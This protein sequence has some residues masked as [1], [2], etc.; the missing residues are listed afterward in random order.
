MKAAACVAVILAGAS[1]SA[2]A[3]N[4][5]D[6]D[7]DH[8]QAS[9][10]A[11]PWAE[12]APGWGHSAGEGSES[13]GELPAAGYTQTFALL[14][15]PFGPESGMFGLGMRGGTEHSQE[16][17]GNFIQAFVS[18]TGRVGPN[19]TSVNLLTNS[20]MFELELDGNPIA[21]NPVGLDP[22][23]AT[24]AED[25]LT[26]A[27]EWTGDVSAFAGQ[28]VELKIIDLEVPPDYSMLIIDQIQ[29]LPVPETPT[30]ALLGLG[31]LTVLLGGAGFP[32]AGRNAAWYR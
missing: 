11:L 13:L 12:A 22:S 26:Y 32:R 15:A 9:F 23:S 6:L 30:V 31:L 4:F 16:P 10:D 19:V 7:F 1:A 8:G 20:P 29:F 25:L 18:Q 2:A 28:V 14:P 27:G 24:Y 17:L 3:Q 21:M 5:M